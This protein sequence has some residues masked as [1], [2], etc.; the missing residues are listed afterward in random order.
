[1]YTLFGVGVLVSMVLPA[2]YHDGASATSVFWTV[3]AFVLGVLA[4]RRLIAAR[5]AL[6]DAP[7][8]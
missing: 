3:V 6:R 7:S 4:L 2:W 1:V 8:P 5:A